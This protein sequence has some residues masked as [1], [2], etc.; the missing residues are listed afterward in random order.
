MDIRTAD[1][2]EG[3]ELAKSFSV[4]AGCIGGDADGLANR[5]E[6]ATASAGGKGMLERQFGIDVDEP[7]GHDQVLRHPDGASFLEVAHLGTRDTIEL[8][9]LDVLVD[10]G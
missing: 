5:G 4:V 2:P 3:P 1:P 6:T 9:A 8:V 10:L 7:S